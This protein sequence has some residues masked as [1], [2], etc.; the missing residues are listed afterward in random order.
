MSHSAVVTFTARPLDWILQDGGSRDWRLDPDRAGKA[1]FLVC[2]QNRHNASF[3][4]PIAPHGAAFLIGRV[5][6][7]VPSPEEPGRWLI[8]FSEY[9]IPREPI[10][11]IWGKLGRQ[12]YPVCYTTLE[13]LGIDLNT[14]P[15]FR[16]AD[17]PAHPPGLADFAGAALLAPPPTAAS[18]Q[19]RRH[20][21]D[22]GMT[23]IQ[24]DPAQRLDAIL[25]QL[26]RIPD[27]PAPIDPLEWDEHGLPR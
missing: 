4:A 11:N 20:Q 26:D 8:K 22:T 15:P 17:A 10:P 1:E 7:V 5:S 16:P 24:A 27:L 2:T 18:Q 19:R 9:T 14:L 3:G 25:A 23:A 13:D 6:G 21:G 12:R